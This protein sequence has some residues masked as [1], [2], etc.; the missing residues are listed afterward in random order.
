MVITV[1]NQKG[2]TGKTSTVLA[3]AQAL[4]Y[5]GK[6]V[7][8]IDL[9][10][11]CN[12]SYILGADI[13]SASVYN[14]LHDDAEASEVIQT[15]GDVDIIAGNIS[16][17]ASDTILSGDA[18]TNALQRKIQ[19]IK[20]NYDVIIIDTPPTFS[21]L[22][23]N[24]LVA[25]DT[26]II[27]LQ[28]D[29]LS[30]QGLQQLADTVRRCKQNYNNSLDI[31]GILFTKHSTRTVLAKDITESIK[32]KAKEWSIPVY[33]TYIR[34]AVALREAQ[35]TQTSLYKYAPKSAPAQDYLKLIEEMKL[36]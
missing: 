18:R 2:G 31:G 34:E 5:K 29:I 7:L 24:S 35:T 32:A 28:A 4:A 15:V 23:I 20:Q 26:V 12:L 1:S 3:M 25:S 17:S 36:I 11:Q 16:L 9:D 19:P 6:K 10:A 13:Q 21:T 27:P 14:L 33:D 8:V 30:L 22:L